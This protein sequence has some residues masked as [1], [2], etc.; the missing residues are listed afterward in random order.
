MQLGHAGAKGSTRAALGR[1]RPAARRRQLAADL[2]LAAAVHR[3]R[4]PVVARDDARRH[5]P[6]ARRLRRIDPARG[7][8][9]LR[10]ARTALRPRLP[11]VVVHL[12]ADQS[13]HRRLRRHA[14]APAAL[15]ARGV[16][17]GARG[18]AAASCR[19]RCA[20]RPRLGRGRHHARRCGGDRARLQGRR[21]RPDRLLVG[22]GQQAGEAGLRPHVPDA[23]RR[24]GAQRGRHRD[25]RGG[26]HH[27]GRPRQQHHRRRPRRPVRGGAPAP[28][29]SG[30]DAD[31]GGAHRLCG[32]GLAEA[33]PRRQGAARAQRSS[34]NAPQPP[35]RAVRCRRWRRPTRRSASEAGPMARDDASHALLRDAQELG[36]EARAGSDDHAVLQP[37]AAHARQHH[38]DRA[39]RS[40][41]GCASASRSRWPAS[42]TW[43]SCTATRTA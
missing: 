12:A 15:S 16:R 30:V 39:P 6:R 25:H 18:L 17:R 29:Q 8:G 31:R 43:R 28:G 36:H 11:A 41:A 22:P 23:V 1:H 4:Q 40:G 14:R 26:R 21:R 42:T 2:G 9:R 3:R 13:P 33:V 37:V 35:R 7:R 24:P 19:C 27:R 20:S 32:R 10:L 34:A 38:P 5:G